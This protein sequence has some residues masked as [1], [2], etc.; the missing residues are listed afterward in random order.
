MKTI[1]RPALVL[2]AMLSLICGVIY[3]YAM[4]GIGQL[5]F[6]G[7]T[8]GSLVSRDGKLVGSL[9][10]GQSFSSARYFWG[11]PSATSP[12]PDNGT[13]S[14]GSNLGPVNP[15]LVEAI[16]GRVNALKA[17]DAGNGGREQNGAAH[18][19]GEGGARLRGPS[20]LG[21]LGC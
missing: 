20:P 15:A 3:P 17:A 4:T 9:L 18:V 21:C 11:R 10:I 1:L 13:A 8:N 16:K 7:Q 19:G 12:M 6:P 14:G 5:A 2:F